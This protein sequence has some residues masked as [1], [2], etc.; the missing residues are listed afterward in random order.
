MKTTLQ[1]I[2]ELHSETPSLSENPPP[3][4]RGLEQQD[5]PQSWPADPVPEAESDA[6]L[7]EALSALEGRLAQ[8]RLAGY[9]SETQGQ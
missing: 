4:G 3:Q 2:N 5:W 8:E 1:E 6:F 9:K 7:R